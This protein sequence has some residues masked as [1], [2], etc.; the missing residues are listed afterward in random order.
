MPDQLTAVA[1]A[2][3]ECPCY[4]IQ[5]LT[6]E[7]RTKDCCPACQHTTQHCTKC[8][9]CKGTGRVPALPGAVRVKCSGKHLAPDGPMID[10]VIATWWLEDG[11]AWIPCETAGCRGW[12]A[13]K[14]LEVWLGAA[15]VIRFENWTPA[16]ILWFGTD[17][18]V[19]QWPSKD[20]WGEAEQAIDAVVSA[21]ARAL[22][23]QGAKLME[24][25]DA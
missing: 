10:E 7:T 2:T 5:R 23:A 8:F 3:V 24:V 17:N 20:C 15:Q 22:V 1:G 11:K 16:P 18:W 12:N 14:S 9:N 19:F 25:T 4:Y 6:G 21:L 13:S